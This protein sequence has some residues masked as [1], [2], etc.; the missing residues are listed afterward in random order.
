MERNYA[1]KMERGMMAR[2]SNTDSGE[3]ARKK[4]QD[5]KNVQILQREGRPVQGQEQAGGSSLPQPGK[6][7]GKKRTIERKPLG[8]L[9]N[10]K[11]REG[12]EGAKAANGP[13]TPKKS[14]QQPEKERE[15]QPGWKVQEPPSPAVI[16]EV[17][18]PPS[19]AV[20]QEVQGGSDLA[21]PWKET[22]ER[23]EA[24]LEKT[25]IYRLAKRSLKFPRALYYCRLCNY[26]I[27]TLPQCWL[28]IDQSRHNR[29]AKAKES[30]NFFKNLPMPSPPHARAL[31]KLLED[32]TEEQALT[33]REM[34][35]RNEVRQRVENA[36]QS[37]LP[38]E[39]RAGML[40]V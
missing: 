26:H 21:E 4:K 8:K 2:N 11:L 31:T 12:E 25:Y 16:Q 5:P 23:Q 24:E 9:V 38:G 34:N 28:H 37:H 1:K 18:E 27:D 15:R 29:L 30:E 40:F 3:E 10:A 22:M 17:Q 19:P 13:T 32:V 35:E 7:S 36:L 33:G 6:G 14:D 20:D 39:N